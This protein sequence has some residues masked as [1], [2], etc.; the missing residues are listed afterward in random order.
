[1]CGLWSTEAQI[2]AIDWMLERERIKVW[3]GTQNFN[4]QAIAGNIRTYLMH[5]IVED[6]E[7]NLREKHEIDAGI[8]LLVTRRSKQKVTY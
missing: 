2:R 6:K 3:N 5:Q 8:T 7:L 1:M 4:W